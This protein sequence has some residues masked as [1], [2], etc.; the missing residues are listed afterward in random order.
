MDGAGRISDLVFGNDCKMAE[1]DLWRSISAT[2]ESGPPS[3]LYYGSYKY[4][5]TESDVH[6]LYDLAADPF[7]RESDSREPEYQEIAACMRRRLHEN[8]D[9]FET[10]RRMWRD[11]R[12]KA[13]SRNSMRVCA[14]AREIIKRDRWRVSA[15]AAE[16]LF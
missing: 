10:I 6:E 1:E 9:R 11:I 8:M 3:V 7:E 13:G 14:V 5:A 12:R 2:S 4:I 15:L 16:A